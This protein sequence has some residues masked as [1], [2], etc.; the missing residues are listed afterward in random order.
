VETYLREGTV[1][2]EVAL[3]GEAVAD[4]TKL[5]LLDILPD[6]VQDIIFGDL[7]HAPAMLASRCGVIDG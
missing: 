3:V 6:R 7:Q 5:A 4:E 1:I 2:P